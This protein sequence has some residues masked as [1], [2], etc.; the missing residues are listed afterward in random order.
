MDR[1]IIHFIERAVTGGNVW[2]E[3]AGEPTMRAHWT[4]EIKHAWRAVAERRA[5]IV[6]HKVTA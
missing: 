1:W 2:H 6:A 5:F 4:R 3:W